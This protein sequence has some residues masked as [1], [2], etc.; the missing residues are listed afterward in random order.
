MENE[1]YKAQFV[2]R[3]C[4]DK[5]KNI[6]VSSLANIP[7]ETKR[8]IVMIADIFNYNLRSQDVSQAYVEISG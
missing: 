5:E 8:M 4:N 1:L 7:Q 2:V 6:I 3:G